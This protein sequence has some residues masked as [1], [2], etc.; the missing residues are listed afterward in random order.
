MSSKED[1]KNLWEVCLVFL[2][3]GVTAFGG[4]AAHIAMMEQ[5]IVEKRKWITSEHFLDLIGATNLIPGPNSTELTM[6]CGYERAGWKG[7]F[8]GGLSFILPATIITG[9]LA[10]IYEVYGELPE[11]APFIS[12][13]KPA[14]IAIIIYAGYKLGKKAL[15]SWELGVIGGLTLIACLCGLNEIIALFSAGLLGII[16]SLFKKNK[17]LT[18]SFL[19][20]LLSQ[21]T[22]QFNMEKWKIFLTFLKV[23]AIL[24]GSGYVLFAF[25]ETELVQTGWLSEQQL[26]DAVA[27]GQFTPGPV[28]STSTFIGWQLGGFWGAILATVG[29]FVPSFFF[30]LVLNKLIPKMKQSKVLQAFLSSVNIAAVALILAVCFEMTKTTFEQGWRSILIMAIGVLVVF[31]FKKLNSAY[32]VLGGAVLGYLLQLI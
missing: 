11:I 28:L 25:L 4:P 16:L 10:W 7:L 27:M 14:V 22:T 23:G 29:M 31:F 8:L 6:H 18:A 19:P 12:G 32:V 3:L 1:R 20:L 9:I 2:K 21:V 5:E 26:L 30:V 24:Y 17:S 15:K 13:I